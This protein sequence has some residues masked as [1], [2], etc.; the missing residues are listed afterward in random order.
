MSESQLEVVEAHLMSC[1][2]CAAQL[3]GIERTLWAKTSPTEAH[4]ESARALFDGPLL[5]V[6]LSLGQRPSISSEVGRGLEQIGFTALQPSDAFWTVFQ[7]LPNKNSPA[8]LQVV[9]EQLFRLSCQHHQLTILAVLGNARTT[10]SPLKSTLAA[11]LEK[12]ELPAESGLWCSDVIAEVLSSTGWHFQRAVSGA[13]KLLL[14]A[15]PS[16]QPILVRVSSRAG[17]VSQQ[18]R[19]LVRTTPERFVRSAEL[20]V[21]ANAAAVTSS[22][23]ELVLSP[24]EKLV[25]HLYLPPGVLAYGILE[26]GAQFWPQEDGTSLEGPPDGRMVRLVF[27]PRPEKGLVRALVLLTK[28]IL[29]QSLHT[30][31]HSALTTEDLLSAAVQRLHAES[32]KDESI[33]VELGTVQV[34]SDDSG[35]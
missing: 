32:G 20:M 25:A 3:A 24:G 26:Q 11:E 29:S 21:M 6:K 30:L 16:W 9:M 23:H 33:L 31:T 15:Q 5:G 14:P 10:D 12:A 27:R 7:F 18:G 1:P 35:A 19:A 13:V 34:I 2:A 22:S 17:A 8:R 4:R 28:S